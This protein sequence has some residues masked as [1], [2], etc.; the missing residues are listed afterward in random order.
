M[1][2]LPY[3]RY[4][5]LMVVSLLEHVAHMLNSFPSKESVSSAMSPATIVEG[6]PKLD[7]NQNRLPFGAYAQVW[8]GT[9]NNMTERAVP[10]IALRASN[11]KGGFYFM[12]LYTGKRINSY[13]WE[14]L[15]ISDEVIE[16]VEEIAQQQKQPQLVNGIPIFEWNQNNTVE[17]IEDTEED[18]EQ[19][20]LI[21]NNNDNNENNDEEQHDNNNQVT[22]DEEEENEDDESLQ[23]DEIREYEEDEQGSDTENDSEMEIPVDQNEEIEIAIDDSNVVVREDENNSMI[24]GDDTEVEAKP[25][26]SEVFTSVENNEDKGSVTQ[27]GI[28]QSARIKSG[29]SRPSRFNNAEIKGKYAQ[30]VQFLTKREET[31][32]H[33]ITKDYMKTMVDVMFTQMS[34]KRG[35]KMFKERAVAA[36]IKELTQLDRGAIDGKPVVIP[37]DPVLLTQENKK[38]AL[39]AVH[40]IKEKRGGDLK[41]RTCADGSKQ[42]QYLKT[43]ETVASP[44]VSMEDLYLTFL[45]AA[46]EGRKVVSFDIP[47]AFLQGEM[48]EDKLLLLKFRGDFV[49]MMCDVNPEHKKNVIFENG[50]KVLYMKIIRGIYGCIEAALQWYKC[51]TEVLEKEGFVLNSYDRCVANKMI[52][53]NQCTIAWYVD[54]NVMTHKSEKVLKN[55]FSKI[56]E[57]FGDMK[58][59]TGDHHEFLGMTIKIHRSDKRI[60]IGMVDQLLEVIDLYKSKHGKLENRYTSPAGHQ[61][62]DINPDEILL[63]TD[64]RELL[65][66]ITQKLLYIMKRGRPDIE[67]AVSFLCTRVRNP[68]LDDWKKLKR[69]LGWLESTI[70]DTRFIGANDLEQLYTWI[71]ASYAVHMDMKGHTG[72]AI[73]MGYGVVHAR[74]GKQKI[75]TKSS[76]ESE[77]VG[78]SEYIPYNLWILMFLE[79]QGYG[80]KENVIYQDNQSAML[81]EKNGRN[82]CTGNSRHINV[83]YFFVKDRID[84]GEV[85]VQYCPTGLM[86]ADYYTK[87]L[88]GA[89]FQEFRNYVMGWKNISELVREI[90]NSDRIKERVGN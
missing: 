25:T 90:D 75:N 88:M 30:A 70:N 89:K 10:G 41:G 64:K 6:T 76:T 20:E 52:D 42:R 79:E 3:K 74:A 59:N 46:Y 54:D 21:E 77:L 71:D 83:R 84:K 32:K 85:R 27:D 35:I 63:D 69:V 9:K 39:E 43:D 50:K 44:T 56:C 38:H 33:E 18:D 7:L 23:L 66:T 53:G 8:I 22:D 86:L 31:N 11:T 14:E 80:I 17:V 72:G 48:T 73:S 2:G 67:L 4:P 24:I 47:G 57:A 82:S 16:R 26:E 19:N 58:L 62:F 15:P 61:L 87:P 13:V 60:E 34:A 12:S 81:M 40:L 65:H 51:Y 29:V 49:D 36:M 1:N 5:K 78:V 55:V 68:S 28:R 37:I 45:I